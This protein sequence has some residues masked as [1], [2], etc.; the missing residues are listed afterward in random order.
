MTDSNREKPKKTPKPKALPATHLYPMT[1]L[2]TNRTPNAHP[3][4]TNTESTMCSWSRERS[5]RYHRRGAIA[6]HST[7]ARLSVRT[8]FVKSFVSFLRAQWY[9]R[10]FISTMQKCNVF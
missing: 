9:F 3:A 10:H 2:A 4:H 1:A 5:T 7:T 6:A 8:V